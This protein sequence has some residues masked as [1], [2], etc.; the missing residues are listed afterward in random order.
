MDR[1]SRDGW[2]FLE[3]PINGEGVGGKI[4][5]LSTAM[6]RFYKPFEFKQSERI[7]LKK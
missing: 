2:K 1:D 7:F 3:N 6:N 5:I 4:L